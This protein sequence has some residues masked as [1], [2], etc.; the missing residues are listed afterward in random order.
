MPKYEV[1]EKSYIN[2]RLVEKGEII[3]YSGIAGSNL[4]SCKNKADKAIDEKNIAED[5]ELK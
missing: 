3:E 4:K 5:S 2:D 1:L